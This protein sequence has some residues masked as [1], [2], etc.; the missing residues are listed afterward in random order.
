MRRYASVALAAVLLAAVVVAFTHRSR[1]PSHTKPVPADRGDRQADTVPKSS[2][3]SVSQPPLDQH[4]IEENSAAAATAWLQRA[5]AAITAKRAHQFGVEV[6][7]IAA[8]PPAEAWDKLTQRAR[9][10]DVQAGAAAM[11]LANE[12]KVLADLRALPRRSSNPVN[13]AAKGLTP[14]W[15]AFAAAIDS[16]QQARLAQRMDDCEGV[17]GVMDFVELALDRFMRPD[18]PEIQLA[19]AADIEGD[20]D[21]IAALRALATQPGSENAQRELGERLMKSRNAAESAEGFLLLQSLA[22]SDEGVT[23]FLAFC[24]H[25]GCGGFPPDPAAPTQWMERAAGSGNVAA[26][27]EHINDLIAARDIAAAWAWASYRL[28]LAIN[29]CFE[30]GAPTST[31]V[32]QAAQTL[33]VL[34]PQLDSTQRSQALTALLAIRQRWLPSA[35]ANLGCA[36]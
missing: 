8:L 3:A 12:C 20:D 22:D 11:L 21:A 32:L 10:G 19:E 24:L 13:S 30:F 1:H 36:L 27:L 23:A 14:E 7:A 15:K 5:D 33:S 31:W 9:D 17:G 28:E 16:Q 34:E 18:N 29:G 26:L 4:S 25:D 6:A 2:A 35:M